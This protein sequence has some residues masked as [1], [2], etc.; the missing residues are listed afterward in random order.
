[1]TSN[2]IPSLVERQGGPVLLP[3]AVSLTAA[4]RAKT[5]STVRVFVI[6][7]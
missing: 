6:Y 2:K 1:M 4:M 3:A 5:W 7:R